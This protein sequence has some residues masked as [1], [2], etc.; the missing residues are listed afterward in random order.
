M[1][2]EL[3]EKLLTK[4]TNTPIFKVYILIKKKYVSK[5]EIIF[6]L[7]QIWHCRSLSTSNIVINISNLQMEQPYVFLKTN[8]KNMMHTKFQDLHFNI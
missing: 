4:H 6:H 1:K 7:H 3:V 5:L 8:N 2:I